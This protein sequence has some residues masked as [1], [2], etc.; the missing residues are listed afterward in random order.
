MDVVYICTYHMS[1]YV[2]SGSKL[3]ISGA[4]GRKEKRG[5]QD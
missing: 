3:K 2:L 5:E 1:V 4:E